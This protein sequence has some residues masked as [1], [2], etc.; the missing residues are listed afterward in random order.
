MKIIMAPQAIFFMKLLKMN[1]K[2]DNFFLW[3][4][5]SQKSDI[6][7][8]VRNK[9]DGRFSFDKRYSQFFLSR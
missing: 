1:N 9:Q 3:R 4:Y 7:W 2:L 8:G 5:F 6:E